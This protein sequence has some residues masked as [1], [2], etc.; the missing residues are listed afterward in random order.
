MK[1]ILCA[2]SICA[3]GGA[4]AAPTLATATWLSYTPT[5]ATGVIADPGGDIDIGL[6]LLFGSSYI[7]GVQNSSSLGAFYGGAT[8]ADLYEPNLPGASDFLTM[9]STN[10]TTL[11]TLT[12]SR[13]IV[14]PV[15]HV[16]N[17]DFR[18]YSFLGGISAN[19]LSGANLMSW[20]NVVGD[21][22]TYTYDNGGFT[23][24]SRGN[25]NGSAYGSFQLEGTFT[26][27]QWTRPRGH[28]PFVTDG[29]W[30]GISTFAVTPP[31]TVAEPGSAALTTLALGLAGMARR[32]RGGRRA[33]SAA[34]PG[35]LACR[36]S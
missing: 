31:A 15:F 18:Y 26:T 2:L 28:S 25:Q 4:Q 22:N 24:S 9:N 17:L 13:A 16:Y 14:D 8:T 7:L 6:S 19:V 3:A 29:S 27:I 35:R 10:D 12:F 36:N 33:V 21:N 11:Y 32:R 23:D 1:K 34:R 30:L 20:S 5:T